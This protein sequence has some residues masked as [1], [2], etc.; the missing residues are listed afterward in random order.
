MWDKPEGACLASRVLV[1]YPVTAATLERVA[2]A[3]AAVH[4]LGFR[5]LR[6]RHEGESARVEV[7]PEELARLFSKREAVVAAV[8]AVGYHAVALDP[9]G[10]RRRKATEDGERSR[11]EALQDR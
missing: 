11:R 5:V 10:Y 4:D 6:V 2:A 3:E 8:R 7:A 1:G 9:A